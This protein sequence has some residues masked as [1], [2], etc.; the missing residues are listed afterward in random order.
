MTFGETIRNERIKR[1]FT[2]QHLA[3]NMEVGNSY[4]RQ[5]ESGA[6]SPKIDTIVKFGK[7]LGMTKRDIRRLVNAQVEEIIAEG[8]SK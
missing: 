3:D 2:I 1:G 5:Y 4:V 8:E 7:G 6:R